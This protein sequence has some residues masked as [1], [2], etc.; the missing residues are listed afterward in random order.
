MQELSSYVGVSEASVRTWVR[1]APSLLSQEPASTGAKVCSVQLLLG[2][3]EA[4]VREV[5]SFWMGWF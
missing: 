2:V 4:Q 5:W 1:R 3:S